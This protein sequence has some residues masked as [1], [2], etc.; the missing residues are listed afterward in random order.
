MRQTHRATND[1]LEQLG[2]QRRGVDDII[3]AVTSKNWQRCIPENIMLTVTIVQA[4]VA[5]PP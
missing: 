1:A 4:G 3:Q 2:K 5:H